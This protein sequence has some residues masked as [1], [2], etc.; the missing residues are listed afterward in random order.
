MNEQ[1]INSERSE[2]LVKEIDYLDLFFLI[3]KKKLIVISTTFIAAILSVIVALNVPNL[4]KSEA[5][6]MSADTDGDGGLAGLTDK[7]GG[8]AGLAGVNLNSGGGNKVQLAL[9]VMQSRRFLTEFIDKHGILIEV[10][11]AESWSLARNQLI[12]DEDIYDDTSKTWVREVRAPY[13]AKPSLLEAY[14]EFRKLLQIN[15]NPDTGMITISIE[16]YSPYLAKSWVELLISDINE[17]MKERDVEEA[18]KSTSYLT[19]QL[20]TTNIADIRSI[21][22]S[23]VEEQARTIMFANVRD[24][25][26]FKTVDPAIV[27]EEKSK[28]SRALI[29]IIGVLLG[30]LFSSVV[31]LAHHFIIQS[32]NAVNL[33]AQR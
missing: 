1:P 4:Y 27:P 26:I 23:L 5:L 29:C 11:A 24:E 2:S 25:Y 7:L 33:G 32:R 18:V 6:I 13:V 17:E 3:W 9:E 12:L 10:M 22:Y 15:E 20:D 28:P 8:L 16:Y 19:G 30:F 31:V 14:K 21:L